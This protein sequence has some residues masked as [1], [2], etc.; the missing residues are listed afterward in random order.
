MISKNWFNNSD[1]SPLFTGGNVRYS[2]EATI[3]VAVDTPPSLSCPLSNSD[4]RT[5][6]LY[7]QSPTAPVYIMSQPASPF[8]TQ[9]SYYSTPTMPHT[10]LNA[11]TP[12]PPPPKPS[13]HE[14][15]RGGTPQNMVSLPTPQQPTSGYPSEFQSAGTQQSSYPQ[16]NPLPAPPTIEEGWLP[17]VVKDKS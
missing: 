2:C 7:Q 13:S 1:V 4:L 17:E 14:P 3:A 9:S 6:H 15:S 12:P 8:P 11:D 10:T 5:P 16:T